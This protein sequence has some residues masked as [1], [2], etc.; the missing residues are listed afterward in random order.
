MTVIPVAEASNITSECGW[1]SQDNQ[2]EARVM[3]RMDSADAEHIFYSLMPFGAA[4]PVL[5][6]VFIALSICSL[7]LN[8]LILFNIEESEDLSWQPRFV[9]CKNLIVS[10]VLQTLT[11]AS[12]VIY[13]L[14]R[15]QAMAFG[16]WCYIQNFVGTVTVFCSLTSITSMALERYLYVCFA[17]KYTVIVTEERV[18]TAVLAVWVYS[19][20]MGLVSTSMLLYKGREVE[21][22]PYTMG[23][24]CEPD[25]MEQHL[26][27]PRAHSLFRKAFGSITLLMCLLAHTFSYFRMYQNASN[28]VVPF[29][30]VNNAARKTVMFYCGMLFLQLLPLLFKVASDALWE[31]KGTDGR[32]HSSWFNSG[33]TPSGIAA[34]FHVSLL[35]MLLVPP[36][37]NPLVYGLRNA[38]I[39]KAMAKLWRRRAENRIMHEPPRDA[40]RLRNVAQHQYLA[41]AA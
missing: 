28:A 37:V 33:C 25:T 13:S 9:L 1:F 23:L 4:A 3:A 31:F 7:V 36:C 12:A 30:E 35:V 27:F 10:D 39:R 40:M 41:E 5:I 6:V 21:T 11:F 18:R 8:L 32:K 2:T 19:V 14:V 34:V 17:L 20:S 38:E 24:M 16:S 22:E 26:G 29:N 15:H